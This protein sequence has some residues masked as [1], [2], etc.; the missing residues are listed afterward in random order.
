[1]TPGGRVQA[2]IE[3]LDAVLAPPIGREQTP[4]D[5]VVAGYTRKRR[6]IG[7]KDRRAV[8]GL[9][10][11]A[12]RF[13]GRA[14]WAAGRQSV[15]GRELA[16]AALAGAAGWS[17]TDMTGAFDGSGYAPACL[18][19]PELQL[20]GAVREA[21]AP[22]PWAAANM[23]AWLA[24]EAELVLAEAGSA[25]WQ[26]LA[27][28]A[29]ATLRVNS[30][31]ASRDACLAALAEA[32]IDAAASA[33][34]P[35][36]IALRSRANLAQLPAVREGWLESQDEGSQIAA[37]LV[38]A[39]P[40]M[41]VL[42]YCAGGG[43]KSLALAAAM[44]NEGT[45]LATDT[46]AGRLAPL[47]RRAQRAGATI[48]ESRIIEPGAALD[49]AAFDRVLVDAPCS[50]SGSWRRQ[51]EAPWRLDPARYTALQVAQ[52]EILSAAAAWVAPG[53]RLVYATCSI[54]PAENDAIVERFLQNNAGFRPVRAGEVWSAVLGTDPPPGVIDGEFVR[55]L[56][57]IA[58]TDGFFIA[59]VERAGP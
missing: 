11:Q 6:Y 50:G 20:A 57:H 8:T 9:V 59:I 44:A 29:P 36:G 54:F 24:A 15:S 26:A 19:E 35:L 12:L 16:V 10:W 37:A 49:A 34:S 58:S 27:E 17:D 53:G 23:P 5:A 40:G 22:P 21:A 43:G 7:S 31:K 13:R 46:D 18:T 33:L 14:L 39:E 48:V 2:A 25:S 1:M 47:A 32:G 42:D 56:P 38:A 41:R 3:L 45:I 52:T 28:E 30:L 55:L 4:A 51:P